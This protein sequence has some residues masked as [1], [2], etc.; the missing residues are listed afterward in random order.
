MGMAASQAR[1]LSLTARLSD[2][3]Y[4][5]QGISNSKIRLADEGAQASTDYENALDAKIFKV[6]NGSNGSFQD[7]SVQ[8]VATYGGIN[9]DGTNSKFRYITDSADKLVITD[10]NANELGLVKGADGSYSLQSQYLNP[11]GGF[12][13][14]MADHGV[15]TNKDTHQYN[16]SDAAYNFY[17]ALYQKLSANTTTSIIGG[18]ITY[19]SKPQITVIT[20]DQATDPVWLENQVKSGNLFLSEF[21][22]TGGKNGTGSF[23]EVSWTSGDN[24]VNEQTDSTQ[25]A[26]AEAKYEAT[27]ADINAKDKRF[28]AEL[29]TIDT[30]HEAIQT[31]ID[32]VKKVID[33]NIER[34]FKIFQA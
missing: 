33:K 4:Q 8:T 2:L 1:L 31:E 17:S 19:Q 27:M 23:D 26:R 18:D 34:S 28:D 21:N 15:T 22:Q 24:T 7:A 10:G 9:I 25:T 6:E 5:A 11:T 20:S 16:T 14:F 13:A 32:S 3:E 30:E 12:D 29:K